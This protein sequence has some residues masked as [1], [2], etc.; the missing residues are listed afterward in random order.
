[1][2]LVRHHCGVPSV[3]I[4]HT[5]GKCGYNPTRESKACVKAAMPRGIRVHWSPSTPTQRALIDW[6]FI[7]LTGWQS[8]ISQETERWE[9]GGERAKKERRKKKRKS[10]VY[11]IK[12]S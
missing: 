7:F 2:V 10:K 11:F 6:S 4:H 12:K 8:A 9:V 3:Y 5:H 1:M